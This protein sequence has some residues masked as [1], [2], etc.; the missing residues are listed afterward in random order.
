MPEDPPT[1]ATRN[2]EREEQERLIPGIRPQ[3]RRA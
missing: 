1:V 2:V 3:W